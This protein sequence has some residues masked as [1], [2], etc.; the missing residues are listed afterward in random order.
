VLTATG[1][2]ATAGNPKNGMT[3]KQKKMLKR[4]LIAS[5]MLLAL[6]FLSAELLAQ[7]DELLFPSAGRWLRFALYLA[8]YFIIGHD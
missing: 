7:V 1:F 6:Q 2:L 3:K 4:I 8:D 5:S